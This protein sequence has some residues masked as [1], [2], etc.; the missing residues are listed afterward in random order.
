MNAWLFSRRAASLI[1]A[2]LLAIAGRPALAQAPDEADYGDAP[3]GATACAAGGVVAPALYPTLFDTLNAVPGRTAPYHVPLDDP[4]EDYFFSAAPTY[5]ASAFQPA[6]DWITP[7]CDYDGGPA[8]L[9]L[10]AACTTGVF[11]APGGPCHDIAAG[12]F[13]TAPTGIG[14]WIYEVNRGAFSTQPGVVNVAVDWDLDGSY[15]S[16]SGEWVERDLS[17]AVLP[18]QTQVFVT[19][20]FPTPTVFPC[21][22][23]LGWCIDPFW[24]RFHLSDEAM[25]GP[26]FDGESTIW[27][28]SGR[29]GGYSGGATVDIVPS[30]DPQIFFDGPHTRIGG[31]DGTFVIVLDPGNPGCI[32]SQPIPLISSPAGLRV[33]RF[34]P[35]P[36]TTGQGVITEM[37]ALDLVGVAPGLGPVRVEERA[38]RM[39]LGKL[40]DV[41]APGG[42]LST[43]DSFFDVFLTVELPNL[44]LRLD[45]GDRPLRM[46]APVSGQFPPLFQHYVPAPGS[47]ALQLFREGTQI[48]VGWLCSA[49]FRWLN[50]L[51]APGHAGSK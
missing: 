1:A 39:S 19:D 31:G 23:P 11:V 22:M 20:P 45:T 9:C 46:V 41:V 30:T 17:V 42:V 14:Y 32:G 2:L 10:N 6:C 29:V 40:D 38:N 44:G 4:N 37:L 50:T 15:G 16:F 33:R 28:G 35:A 27:D 51:R 49:Q 13:G 47:H 43:C 36:F 24:S 12:A 25:I 3:D 34:G 7:P 5:E 26:T 48:P 8:I 18:W 21:G